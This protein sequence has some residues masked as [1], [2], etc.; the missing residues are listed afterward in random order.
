MTYPARVIAIR[1]D[2]ELEALDAGQFQN[3][4]DIEAFQG[5]TL[6]TLLQAVYY[7]GPDTVDVADSTVSKSPAI[8][9]ISGILPGGRVLVRKSGELPGFVGLAAGERYYLDPSVPGAITNLYPPGPYAPGTVQQ[10][11]GTAQDPT[12]LDCSFDTDFIQQA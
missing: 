12:T 1:E 4:S 3:L 10:G 9:I 5:L 8:G 7:S 6:P 11:V 2:G